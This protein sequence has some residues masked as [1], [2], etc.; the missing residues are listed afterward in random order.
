MNSNLQTALGDDV[1]H[2]FAVHIGQS[3]IATAVAIGELLV[4][5][6]HEM[7]YRGVQIMHVHSI[8]DG[9]DNERD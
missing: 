6:T 5:K 9:E 8:L 1:V 3:I 2:D 4:I 7:Q